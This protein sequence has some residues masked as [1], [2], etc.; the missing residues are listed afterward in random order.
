MMREASSKSNR[1][2][3]CH[4]GNSGVVRTCEKLPCLTTARGGVD[5]LHA[6]YRIVVR[7][8]APELPAP[9]YTVSVAAIIK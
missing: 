5:K 6:R 1:A 2:L 9:V 7:R 4:F 8:P 3:S